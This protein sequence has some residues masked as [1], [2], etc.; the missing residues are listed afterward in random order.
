MISSINKEIKL[1]FFKISGWNYLKGKDEHIWYSGDKNFVFKIIDYLR[2]VNPDFNKIK[3]TLLSKNRNSSIVYQRKKLFFCCTD[4]ARS[5]PI[6]FNETENSINIKNSCKD[7][8][9]KSSDINKD[10]IRQAKLTGYCLNYNTLITNLKI[11]KPGEFFIANNKSV[12]YDKYFDYHKTFKPKIKNKQQLIKELSIIIDKIAEYFK[13]RYNNKILWM[14]IS[15][16]FDSRL[17]VSKFHEKGIKNIKC[18]SYGL[19]NNSDALIGKKVCQKLNIPW[20]FVDIK[21]SEYQNFY[22]SLQKKSYD[23]F[24]DNLQVIPNYQEFLVIRKL[25]EKKLLTKNSVIIN[26]QSG[27]F[28]SGGHIPK[29]LMRNASINQLFLAI[30]KKHFFLIKDQNNQDNNKYIDK[31]LNNY[32]SVYKNS[33]TEKADLYENWEYYERQVKYVVNGQRTY[34]YFDLNWYLPLWDGEFVKFW[35][36][37]PKKFRYKQNLYLS[38]LKQWNYKGLFNNNWKVISFTGIVGI[39]IKLISF[40]LNFSSFLFKKNILLQYFDYFS[41]YGF[42][43]R[44]FGFKEFVVKRNKIRNASS[45]HLISWLKDKKLNL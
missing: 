24:C 18:F 17:L 21:D 2:S 43:Y 11:M 23:K 37:V 41:R 33:I 6:F 38:Y 35:T 13:E 39:M 22:K 25:V 30:K 31:I 4:F 44:Y 9:Y 29:I 7:I 42:A 5:Y 3:K 12:T 8:K 32:F 28:N 45:L 40:T 34:D 14:P 19:K 26:G 36:K 10:A 15:G 1:N 20:I 27:D 16:G